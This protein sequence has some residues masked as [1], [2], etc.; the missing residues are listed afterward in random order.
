M[1]AGKKSADPRRDRTP[2]VRLSLT[3]LSKSRRAEGPLTG[4]P[5]RRLRRAGGFTLIELAIATVVLLVGI[6]AVMKLVPA[7]MRANRN[8]RF[9]TTALVIGQRELDQMI[10]Q[11]LAS[12]QFV[13]S[14]GRAISLGGSVAGAAPVAFGGPVTTAGAWTRI[15][16][17][18]PAVAGYNYLYTDP[19]SS[20]GPVYEV[21]WAVV[22]QMIG[23]AVASKRFLVGVWKRDP[24]QV[25]LPVTLDAWV[26]R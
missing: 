16:F 24:T 17:T 14:D 6:L 23:T 7:A 15:D 8:S 20:A 3:A 11:P 26:K 4:R 10:S 5:V 1:A 18:A 22:V 12:A 13:D 21:R 19:N 25:T 9:D 2:A